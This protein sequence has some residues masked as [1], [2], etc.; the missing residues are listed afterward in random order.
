MVALRVPRARLNLRVMFSIKFAPPL[1]RGEREERGP[2]QPLSIILAS[3]RDGG[4]ENGDEKNP[5]SAKISF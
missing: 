4:G 3:S 2:F 5:S 1:Q